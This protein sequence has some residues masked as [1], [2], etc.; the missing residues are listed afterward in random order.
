[1]NQYPEK[2]TAWA[3]RMG[4][5]NLLIKARAAATYRDSLQRDDHSFLWTSC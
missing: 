1:M 3:G 5:L 2:L 4:D